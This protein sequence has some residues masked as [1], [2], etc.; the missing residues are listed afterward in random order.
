MQVTAK[1]LTAYFCSHINKTGIKRS[2][3]NFLSSTKYALELRK[4]NIKN[5]LRIA[6]FLIL[7]N[8]S[9]FLA[10]DYEKVFRSCNHDSIDMQTKSVLSVVWQ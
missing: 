4:K 2:K 9:A 1:R 8:S 10:L 3:S 6:H 5:I 7:R